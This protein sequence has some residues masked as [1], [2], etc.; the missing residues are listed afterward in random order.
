MPETSAITLDAGKRGILGRAVIIHSKADDGGQPSGN[1][2]ERIAAGVIGISK[3]AKPEPT[4]APATGD[5]GPEKPTGPEQKETRPTTPD[6]D[7][8][9]EE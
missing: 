3:D 2:G 9:V 7:E 5:R 4:P 1:A 8:T 6:S